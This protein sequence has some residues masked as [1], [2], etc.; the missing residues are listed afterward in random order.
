MSSTRRKGTINRKKIIIIAAVVL[1]VLLG[2]V[3][4]IQ[5]LRS[6]VSAQF[7]NNDEAEVLSAQVSVGSIS[8]T[9]SGSGTLE[10]EASDEIVIPDT[11]TISD[12]YVRNSDTVEAGEMIAAVNIASLMEAMSEIQ[13]E[14]DALDEELADLSSE[15]VDDTISTG[16]AGR[17]KKIYAEKGE[18]VANV[19][20]EHSALVLISVDGYMAVD[21]ETDALKKDDSVTVKDSA[22]NTYTGTVDAVWAGKATVLITDNGTTYGD[23]VTVSLGDDK[24]ATGTLYIHEPVAITGYAGTIS[25]I[26]VS[27]NQ[28]VSAG[29]T[30]LTLKDT[31]KSVNYATIL[32]ERKVL[33]E[34]LQD[35]VVI[36]KEGAVY[37][38]EAGIITEIT[39]AS[40]TVASTTIAIA[41]LNTMS[42]SVSVD[43]TNILALSVGQEATIS[44]DSLGD[45][46][47]TGTVSEINK[48]GSSSN[49]VTAYSATIELERVDGMLQGMSASAVIIIEGKDDA[50]LVPEEAVNK[51]SSTAY[52]YTTYD[53]DSG[54][55]GGM[56]EVTIGLS[57]GTYVE[58]TEGLSEGDTVYYQEAAEE[59]FSFGNM[60][61]PGGMGGGDFSMP[62]GGDF[63]MP[64]GGFGGGSGMPSGMPSGGFSGGGMPSGRN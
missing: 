17:V 43:E 36:Y 49:G 11:V 61:M 59:G 13:A 22:G 50:L 55:F 53:E 20:Y 34:S 10:N 14:L 39:E 16:V 3:T 5:V 47:Y 1:L 35:L 48:T 31:S 19:M 42:M 64:S 18:T 63:N 28:K 27:E 41:P 7:G 40:D 32:E 57:N 2:I 25:S 37:A 58:I 38:K 12:I 54:E 6:R 45:E 8:T 21:V 23:E 26:S 52:V 44:I 15:E 33:E 30:L 46:N 60:Q 24:T 9:V 29:K 4:L 62:G 56:V 51:T